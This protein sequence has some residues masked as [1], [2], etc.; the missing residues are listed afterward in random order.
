MCR[1]G[2]CD[3]GV[4]SGKWQ[5]KHFP[6]TAGAQGRAGQGGAGETGKSK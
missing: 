4:E 1:C 6:P 3:M 5:S 2:V